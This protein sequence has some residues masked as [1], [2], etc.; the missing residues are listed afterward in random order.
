MRGKAHGVE[1]GEVVDSVFQIGF[2]TV[3]LGWHITCAPAC[4]WAP[5]PFSAVRVAA[6]SVTHSADVTAY[7]L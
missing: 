5:Q 2:H 3:H 6:L 7:V 1:R 4:H